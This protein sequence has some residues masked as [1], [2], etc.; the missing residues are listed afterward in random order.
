MLFEPFAEGFDGW[1]F[2]ERDFGTVSDAADGIERTV[3]QRIPNG[4]GFPVVEQEDV[5]ECV[6]CGSEGDRLAVDFASVD[7]GQSVE[8]SPADGDGFS[9][10]GVVDEFVAIEQR[11]RVGA[12]DAVVL[13][14][15]D[16]EF[17]DVRDALL[18]PKCR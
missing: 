15:Y 6:A 3:I 18:F 1:F 13:I 10:D 17:V 9:A 2:E 7:H 16:F 5:V 4:I 8:R 14:A 12:G 11:N